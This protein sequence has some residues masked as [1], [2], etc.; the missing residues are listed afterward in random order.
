MSNFDSL[1]LAVLAPGRS[2]RVSAEGEEEEWL[3]VKPK[4]AEPRTQFGGGG[5]RRPYY[6]EKN[7]DRKQWDKPWTGKSRYHQVLEMMVSN[8]CTHKQL[9][10]QGW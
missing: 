6:H 5:T 8:Y 9:D 1:C 10:T 7:S 3:L 4:R 2:Y